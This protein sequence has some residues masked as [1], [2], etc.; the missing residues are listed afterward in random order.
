MTKEIGTVRLDLELEDG[1][2]R[3]ELV[4]ILSRSSPRPERQDTGSVL[5][6]T[7]LDGGTQHA[8]RRYA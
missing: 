6:E 1:I 5:A 4:K 7:Q 3:I 2:A 8:R